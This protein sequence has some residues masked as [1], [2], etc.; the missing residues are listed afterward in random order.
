MVF[1]GAKYM[2]SL[3]GLANIHEGSEIFA[4]TVY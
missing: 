3:L 2:D 4:L 1:L